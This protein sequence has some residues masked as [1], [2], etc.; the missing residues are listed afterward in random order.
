MATR[1]LVASILI[2]GAL[3]APT[4]DTVQLP[5]GSS[6]HGD[7]NLFCQPTKWSDVLVFFL[8][9]YIAHAATVIS[10]P[11]TSAVASLSQILAALL[12]PGSGLTRAVE[13]IFTRSRLQPDDIKSAQR[14]GALITL[15]DKLKFRELEPEE[16]RREK[17]MNP[18]AKNGPRSKG[19]KI[20]TDARTLKIKPT[21]GRVMTFLKNRCKLLK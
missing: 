7:P 19:R 5:P 21:D 4:N 10:K 17:R 12:L 15:V 2:Y 3:S 20:Q 6:N 1:A 16:Q 13:A 18:Y 9:N 11:G 8:G 14:A